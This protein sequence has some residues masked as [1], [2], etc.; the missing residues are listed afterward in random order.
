ME[1]L[2]LPESVASIQIFPDILRP[3]L[4]FLNKR[5]AWAEC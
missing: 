1:S 2:A 3:W 5:P 4:K